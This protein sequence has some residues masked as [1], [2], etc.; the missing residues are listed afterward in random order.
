MAKIIKLRLTLDIDYIS[1]GVSQDELEKTLENMLNRAAD[2]G[3]MT[4]GVAAEVDEWRFRI[5]ERG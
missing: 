4:Y 3:L 1:N 2:D 5:A